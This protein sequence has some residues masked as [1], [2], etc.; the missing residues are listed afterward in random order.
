MMYQTTKYNRTY[1]AGYRKGHYAGFWDYQWD[2]KPPRHFNK[3]QKIFFKKG[4]ER[5]YEDGHREWEE[6]S[7]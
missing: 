6:S 3:L 5:G 2:T 7:A 1:L 4:Y